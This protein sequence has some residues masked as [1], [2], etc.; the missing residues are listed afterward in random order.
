MT[1]QN[2]Y[3]HCWLFTSRI[4]NGNSTILFSGLFIKLPRTTMHIVCRRGNPDHFHRAN[5]FCFHILW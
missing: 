1:L 4:G 5:G 2:V 3:T